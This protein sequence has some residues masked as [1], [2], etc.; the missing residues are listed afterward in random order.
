[1]FKSLII[2]LLNGQKM[3]GIEEPT[4]KEIVNRGEVRAADIQRARPLE[5]M[6]DYSWYC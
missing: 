3:M 6:A 4:Y 1:M 2:F 5:V